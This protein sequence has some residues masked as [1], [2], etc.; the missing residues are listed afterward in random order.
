MTK[1]KLIHLFLALTPFFFT[2][3]AASKKIHT[4]EKNK[5]TVQLWFNEGWNERKWE[6]LIPVCFAE[7]WTDGNPIRPTQTDGH[8]GMRQLVQSYLT[9]FPD[10]NFII[11]H[12][13]GDENRVA[14]RFEVS[15]T[16]KGNLFDIEPTGR[17]IFT[18]GINIF[19]MENGKI[20]M[21]WSE[22]DLAGLLSQVKN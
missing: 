18:S 9:A 16:H 21:T 6:T 13:M 3:C 19:E 2:Q 22:L 1:F 8:E 15:G 10:I 14:V 7:D 11:T 4:A 20:K 17:E 5:E 12:L